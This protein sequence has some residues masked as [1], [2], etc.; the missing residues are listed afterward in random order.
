MSELWS[1]IVIG[2][3]SVVATVALVTSTVVFHW[4]TRRQRNP[5]PGYLSGYI[6][7]G[8]ARPYTFTVSLALGNTGDIPIMVAGAVVR[9]CFKS[10]CFTKL[11]PLPKV[12]DPDTR[13]DIPVS[14]IPARRAALVTFD[15][16]ISQIKGNLSEAKGKLP[17]RVDLAIVSMSRSTTDP[18]EVYRT[19]VMPI[20][21]EGKGVLIRRLR[22]WRMRRR[23]RRFFL[24]RFLRNFMKDIQRA[25][26]EGNSTTG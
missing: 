3:V 25:L 24:P 1:T 17:D 22:M 15:V 7:R 12:E 9:L 11:T 19:T 23:V 4:W 16:D 14:G 5:K 8:T 2:S 6:E 18:L 20:L 26:Q 13:K 21:P 10:S